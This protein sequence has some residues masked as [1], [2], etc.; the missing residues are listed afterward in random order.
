MTGICALPETDATQS[1]SE[2]SPILT[3]TP[4]TMLLALSPLYVTA[5]MVC[6]PVV[7]VPEAMDW[8]LVLGWYV[9]APAIVAD[10]DRETELFPAVPEL[11]Y[12]A[13]TVGVTD[14]VLVRV[15]VP[16]DVLMVELVPE[17]VD[18]AVA[19]PADTALVA[20]EE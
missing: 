11:T 16:D 7:Y 15:I 4:A 20:C 1:S 9:V 12:P 13:D 18:G 6:A 5:L 14:T 10:A 17:M 3:V 8:S 2:L 19:D